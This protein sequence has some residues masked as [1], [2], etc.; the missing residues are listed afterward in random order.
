MRKHRI[1]ERPPNGL[2]DLTAVGDTVNVAARLESKSKD[3]GWPMVASLATIEAAGPT[4]QIAETREIEL[5]GR[6]ARIQVGRLASVATTSP[7]PLSQVALE[8]GFSHQSHLARSMRKTLG[9]TPGK[10]A[11]AYR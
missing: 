10:L 8:A 3:L 7:R 4:F 6:E 1:I 11:R 2:G 9:V 5:H